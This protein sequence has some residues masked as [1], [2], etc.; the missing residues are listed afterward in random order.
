MSEML[1]SEINESKNIV[2]KIKRG[3]SLFELDS[4]K[5]AQSNAGNTMVIKQDGI[6]EEFDH[7]LDLAV[8]D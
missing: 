6:K 1:K 4:M 3:F 2:E 5:K 8:A 7:Y